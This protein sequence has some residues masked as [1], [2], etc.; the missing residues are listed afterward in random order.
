[1]NKSAKVSQSRAE[2]SLS[3]KVAYE[4]YI[5]IKYLS[6]RLAATAMLNPI[7]KNSILLFFLRS[8]PLPRWP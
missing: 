1:M 7:Q 8:A 4:E 6:Q 2:N 3:L 5:C